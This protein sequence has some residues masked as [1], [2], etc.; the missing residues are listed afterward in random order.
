MCNGDE[1]DLFLNLIG[2]KF[3]FCENDWKQRF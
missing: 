1:L 2:S 3:F